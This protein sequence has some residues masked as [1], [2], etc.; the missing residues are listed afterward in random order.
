M[1]LLE[2]KSYLLSSKDNISSNVEQTLGNVE[3]GNVQL[4]QANR[5]AVSVYFK[6]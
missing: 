5:Y 6:K 3:S 1:I 2:K 4:I